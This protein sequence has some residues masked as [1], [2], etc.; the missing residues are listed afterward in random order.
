MAH[1]AALSA[2]QTTL[3]AALVHSS[4]VKAMSAESKGLAAAHAA[5]QQRA[6]SGHLA[7]MKDAH[8]RALE[9]AGATQARAAA[10]IAG[11][12]RE[13]VVAALAHVEAMAP[14]VRVQ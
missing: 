14:G 6:V 3:K 9:D 12:R 11:L 4:A 1:G 5:A 10:E 13:R 7:A 8:A 2:A